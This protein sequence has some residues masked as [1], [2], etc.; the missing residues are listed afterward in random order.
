MVKHVA[1]DVKVKGTNDERRKSGRES[2]VNLKCT[3][4]RLNQSVFPG[5]S[6]SLSLSAKRFCTPRFAILNVFIS[7]PSSLL[8]AGGGGR[9]H[10]L[11]LHFQVLLFFFI[12]NFVPVLNIA[13][14]AAVPQRI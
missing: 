5:V 4:I 6:L 12:S 9:R 13:I 14:E 1:Y 8:T 2:F 11:F 7:T 10:V 3:I